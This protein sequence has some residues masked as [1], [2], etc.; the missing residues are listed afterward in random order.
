MHAD[1][2]EATDCVV[3]LV[4]VLYQSGQPLDEVMPY[5]IEEMHASR[6]RLDNTA[7]KLDVMTQ[8]DIQLNKIVMRFIDGI[9]RMCTGT[10]E[11]S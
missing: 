1:T 9:R 3:N 4:P 5:L 6:D 11:Y 7:A 10:L 8:N 2:L